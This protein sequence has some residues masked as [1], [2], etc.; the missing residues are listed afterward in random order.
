MGYKLNIVECHVKKRCHLKWNGETK[1]NCININHSL[2][3]RTSEILFQLTIPP[4]LSRMVR[5]KHPSFISDVTFSRAFG[6]TES[7]IESAKRLD[8][9]FRSERARNVEA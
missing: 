4:K 2:L 9:F 7:P 1:L 3:K 5:E 6:F 8:G